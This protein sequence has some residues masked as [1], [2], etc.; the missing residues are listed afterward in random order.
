LGADQ[1]LDPFIYVS[2]AD[3]NG[4]DIKGDLYQWGRYTDGHEKRKSTYSTTGIPL[5][6]DYDN[7]VLAYKAS[8]TDFTYT[9]FYQ[10]LVS[11]E[12]DWISDGATQGTAASSRKG[13]DDATSN[14]NQAKTENDPCPDGWK[15][16]SQ[17][18]WG[19]IFQGGTTNGTPNSATANSWT[20]TDTDE[21]GSED[22][23]Q[24]GAALFLPAAGYRM[25]TSG[26]LGGA[27]SSG[28]YWSSTW[29]D[30]QRSYALILTSSNVNPAS[31]GSL[32][33]YGF[34]VRCVAE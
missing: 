12:Y 17:K 2:T 8:G 34:S 26:E 16:P 15:V 30:N 5:L 27:G 1:T 29:R 3:N 31:T 14:F 24:V 32:R 21:D 9:A 4:Y 6:A 18:Q 13:W 10:G 33:A 23:Y 22:G 19:S 20:W 28:R 11:R 25:Y 7:E